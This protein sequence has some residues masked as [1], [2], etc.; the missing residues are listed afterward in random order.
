[1]RYHEAIK[2][3]LSN[4]AILLKLGI[5]P[6]RDENRSMFPLGSDRQKFSSPAGS[7]L[8]HPQSEQAPQK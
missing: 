6:Q 2:H 4:H 8:L 5:D 3:F 7:F 1:M